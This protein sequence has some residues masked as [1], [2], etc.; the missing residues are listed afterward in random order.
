[1]IDIKGLGGVK[2]TD[3]TKAKAK[4]SGVGGPSFADML[5]DA[6]AAD[7]A[8]NTESMAGNLPLAGGFVPLEE[9]LPRDAQGQAREL[10]KTLKGLAEDALSGSPTA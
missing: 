2:G 6:Q 7:G 9:D 4:T 1:M 10:L 8:A 3:K 5:D